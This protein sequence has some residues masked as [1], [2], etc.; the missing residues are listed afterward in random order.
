MA[1]IINNNCI[2]C[3]LCV[4]ECP[5][6][7]IS[8]GGAISTINE[9]ECIDCGSCASVCPVGACTAQ[10]GR[11]RPIRVAPSNRPNEHSMQ[12]ANQQITIAN[13]GTIRLS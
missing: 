3:T 5:V 7:S 10:G 6:G 1:Y 4:H 12:N 13:D 2:C 9:H 11:Q 8:L